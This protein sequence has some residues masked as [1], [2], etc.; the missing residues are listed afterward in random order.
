M[1]NRFVF[2]AA[3]AA[4]VAAGA[5]AVAGVYQDDLTKCI[6]KSTSDGDKA[7]LIQW[8]FAAMSGNEIVRK[9]STVTPAQ[10]SQLSQAYA[11]MSQ[12]LLVT[13]CRTETVAA[14]K[15]E[16]G[17]VIEQSFS[18]LGQVAMRGLM[19]GPAMRDALQELSAHFDKAKLVTLFK[20]AGITDTST[21][22]GAK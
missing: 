10:R 3:M 11:Q 16:G 17:G 6:V 7:I 14:L 19:S 9:M 13:D 18:T 4:A 20:D 22:N 2:G 1:M 5:P 15:Y 12:R 21:T 8:V